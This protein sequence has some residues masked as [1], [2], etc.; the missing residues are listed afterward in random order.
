MTL[1]DLGE[2]ALVRKI[3]DRFNDSAVP[4][5]IG[6]DAAIVDIPADYSLVYCSDLVAENTHFTRALHPPDSVGYK[7]VA[8]NVS[9]IGA[10]GGIPM[11]FLVSFAAPGNL[12]MAWVDGFF[13]GIEKA[14]K[15]FGISLVGGDSST[16]ANIF[17]DVSMIG[18]VRKGAAVLRSGAQPGDGVYITGVLGSSSLGLERL[19]AG[20]PKHASVL[21]HLYPEPRHGLGHA[22]APRSHA[23]IDVSDGLSTDL[24]HI[25]E[26]SRVSARIYRNLIPAAPDAAD[27]QVLHGGEEYE[28]IIVAPEL[29]DAMEAVPITRIGEIVESSTDHQVFLIDGTRESVL[30]PRGWQHFR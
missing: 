30:H 29:P 28:L 10:M 27:A 23:M 16:A 1:S 18:R 7:A 13:D 19:Q 26:E 25:V 20:D 6:D 2:S 12:E 4:A 15:R 8:V 11:H 14:C 24:A 22:V 21:R 9:D 17:V 3:R 5:G